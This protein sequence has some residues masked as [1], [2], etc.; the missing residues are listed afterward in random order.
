[1]DI[2]SYCLNLLLVYFI[3]MEDKDSKNAK[4]VCRHV[5][6]PIKTFISKA[7]H[8]YGLFEPFN[9]ETLYKTLSAFLLQ[10]SIASLLVWCF[11]QNFNNYASNLYTHKMCKLLCLFL[12]SHRQKSMYSNKNV[13]IQRLNIESCVYWH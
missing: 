6:S 7:R 9:S 4:N 10:I 13:Y 1:M 12:Y 5:L 8:A 3:W 11:L 2:C